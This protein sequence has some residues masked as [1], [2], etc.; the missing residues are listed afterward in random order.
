MAIGDI[1]GI[2]V[3][4]TEIRSS[5]LKEISSRPFVE[6]LVE[7]NRGFYI[8]VSNP[9]IE[10]VSDTANTQSYVS[11]PIVKSNNQI[12]EI[13]YD[14]NILILPQPAAFFHNFVEQYPK[15]L[16]LKENNEDFKVVLLY[17]E[18]KHKNNFDT[19][20]PYYMSSFFKENNIEYIILNHNEKNI[21]QTISAKSIYLFY[22][23]ESGINDPWG[24]S[25]TCPAKF[26]ESEFSFLNCIYDIGWVYNHKLG[27]AF[28]FDSLRKSFK[29]VIQKPIPG[30]KIFLARN[31]ATYDRGWNG[32]E[33]FYD[34]LYNKGFEI[35]YLENHSINNQIKICSSAEYIIAMVGSNLVI[36]MLATNKTKIIS[37]HTSVREEY[38]LYHFQSGRNDGIIKSIYLDE[39]SNDIINYF[40]TSKNYLIREA[41]DS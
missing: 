28:R 18:K 40:E 2:S 36:P 27:N 29:N 22:I 30:K 33:M 9:L 19:Y 3:S 1:K 14:E 15:I 13:H 10:I 25:I 21:K 5:L 11:I 17:S 39:D 34:Y 6:N 37:V 31:Y 38:G 41:I 16:E 8:K 20:I 24:K 7:N 32:Y 26:Y 12:G 23:C 4:N 35:I